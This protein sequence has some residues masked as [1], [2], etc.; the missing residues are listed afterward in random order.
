VDFVIIMFEAKQLVWL[1]L[2]FLLSLI[3]LVEHI[4]TRLYFHALNLHRHR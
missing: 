2:V 4:S 3:Y 1:R